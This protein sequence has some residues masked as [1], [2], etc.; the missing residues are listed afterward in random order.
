[1]LT[2]IRILLYPFTPVY[3]LIVTVR[4]FL[5]DKGIFSSRKVNSD[6]ISVGN[7]PVGGSGKTPAV[8]Y[9]TKLLKNNGRKPA[10]LSRG[11]LRKSKGYLLVS[12]G[13]ELK[14]SVEKCGDEIYQTVIECQV[15]AA[16]SEC[17]VKGANKL[18]KDVNIDTIVLDD[19]FQHRWIARDINLLIFEQR[20][21]R[22]IKTMKQQL[23]PTGNMREPFSSINRADAIIINRKFSDKAVL[24]EKITKYFEGKKIFTSYYQSNGFYDLKTH[25]FYSIKDFHGQHS[26]VVSGIANPFSF[27]NALRQANVNTAH[28]IIFRDHKHYTEKEIQLIRKEFYASNAYSVITTHKDAVKLHKYSKELDD[29]DIYYLQIEL[30]MDD[31][32]DFKNFI[33]NKLT[34]TKT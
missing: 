28:K 2:T 3:L 14:T 13:N 26:L 9:L 16:V 7:I 11:Y 1:M 6:V 24:P 22:G 17:R 25:T 10:V 23:L 21:L 8:I 27:L 20:F 5:F 32:K 19:A 33:F 29:I 4:N 15:P 31:D 18:L 12:D 30:K 34:T